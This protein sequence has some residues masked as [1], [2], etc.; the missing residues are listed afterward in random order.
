MTLDV[1]FLAPSWLAAFIIVVHRE[2]RGHLGACGVVGPV[3]VRLGRGGVDTRCG[4]SR[5]AKRGEGYRLL[6]ALRLLS[7]AGVSSN[8]RMNAVGLSVFRS[9]RCSDFA[10]ICGGRFQAFNSSR[11]AKSLPVGA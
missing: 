8:R 7:L 5:R 4:V 9:P 11:T 2:R 1:A 3:L 10:P 6:S